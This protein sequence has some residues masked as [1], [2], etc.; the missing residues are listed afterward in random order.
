MNRSI[1]EFLEES[2]KYV[3]E[4]SKEEIIKVNYNEIKFF[5]PTVKSLE[6]KEF[7]D[8]KLQE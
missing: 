7:V 5:D 8:M 2:K 3:G 1:K 4:M 6:V